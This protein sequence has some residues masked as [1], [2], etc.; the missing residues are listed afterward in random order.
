MTV[1]LSDTPNTVT[2][3]N[4]GAT[5]AV[6]SGAA[7]TLPT[8]SEGFVVGADPA[9]GIQRG[10]VGTSDWGWHDLIGAVQPK[11]TGANTP[12]LVAFRG[13]QVRAFYFQANDKIDFVYHMPHDWV[14]GTDLFIHAHW[15]HNGTNISG[16]FQL[17]F[18]TTFARGFNQSSNGE[19]VAE[20]NTP[21]SVGSL[22]IA[23]TPQYRHRVDEVQL[24]SATPT[25]NQ[26]DTA[27]LETD[28]LLLMTAVMT[29][30][31]TIT[32]GAGF[33][34]IFTCDIHYQSS[35]LPTPGKTPNFY[36]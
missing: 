32:G 26:L 23:N 22:S 11:T 20:V 35:G 6:T 29:T 10:D 27:T 16:T 18:Y 28:G 21:L 25:A 30:V 8:G 31:P 14:P 33:P 34:F 2:V 9:V 12:T 19:F 17:D 7:I 5:V 36:T 4:D 15:G 13:G 24:T 1:S 3:S